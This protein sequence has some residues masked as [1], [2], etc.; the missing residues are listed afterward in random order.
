MTTSAPL[1]DLRDTQYAQVESALLRDSTISPQCKALYSLL[2]TY[3]PVAIFP[4]QQTLA[5]AL[6]VTR[7]SINTW[8]NELRNIGVIDWKRRG[9][10]SNEYIIVGYAERKTQPSPERVVKPALQQ[11]PSPADNR[12]KAPL[13]RSRS[14]Y[15]DPDNHV[16]SQKN[17]GNVVTIQMDEED[18][19]FTCSECNTAQPWPRTERDRKTRATLSCADCGTRFIVKGFKVFGGGPYTYT[20]PDVR[21]KNRQSLECSLTAAFCRLAQLSYKGLSPKVRLQWERQISD[22]AGDHTTEEIVTAIDSMSRIGGLENPWM[23][24]FINPF[25]VALQSGGVAFTLDDTTGRITEANEEE[26]GEMVLYVDN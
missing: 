8:L 11:M 17:D 23:L 7:Q 3:G 20:H 5:D 14:I 19:Q 6:G 16:P 25:S 22:V 24:R 1:R 13:T 15:P 18:E 12:C 10:T 4:G 9:S 2:I 26:S 21:K